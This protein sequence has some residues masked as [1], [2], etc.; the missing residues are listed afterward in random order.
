MD[1]AVAWLQEEQLG[2]AKNTWLNIW[3][4]NNE[5]YQLEQQQ[6]MAV[7]NNNNTNISNASLDS[8]TTHNNNNNSN[9]TNEGAP[10][11]QAQPVPSSSPPIEGGKGHHHHSHSSKAGGGDAS[12]AVEDTTP[13]VSA[14]G[15]GGGGGGHGGGN[16]MLDRAYNPTRRKLPEKYENKASTYNMNKYQQKLIRK[17]NGCPWRQKNKKYSPGILGWVELNWISQHYFTAL[18]VREWKTELKYLGYYDLNGKYFIFDW[19]N[20]NIV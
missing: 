19:N 13:V 3:E 7:T 12:S 10:S 4:T 18:A 11:M 20:I 15:P 9:K 1:A 16:P 8:N 5:I 17:Y 6:T 2:P 14:N